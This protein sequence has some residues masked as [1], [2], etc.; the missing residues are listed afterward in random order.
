[1]VAEMDAQTRNKTFDLVPPHPHQHVIPTK[2]IHTIK[3][4]PDGT[5]DRHMSWWVARGFNQ[6]QRIDYAETFSPVVKSLTIRLV[7]QLAISRN[8]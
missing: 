5:I 8:W 3:Y 2:W 1:M 7:L 4:N 6:Q